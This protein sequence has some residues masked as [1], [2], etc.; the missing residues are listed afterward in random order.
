MS[1]LLFGQ[2]FGHIPERWSAQSL[3][4]SVVVHDHQR[5]NIAHTHESAFVSLMLAGQY[6]E[7]AGRKSFSYVP[8]TAVGHPSEL[9]HH[10]AIGGPG[11]R[12]LF[13]EFRPEL[14]NGVRVDPTALRS[15]RDLSGTR[16]AW[17]LLSLYLDVAAGGE[18]LEFESRAQQV[19]ADIVRVSDR[20]ASDLPSLNR[21]TEYL[22]AHF[23]DHIAMKDVAAAAS[24]HP[25]YL[26]QMFRRHT[27]ETIGSYVRRLRVRAAAECLTSTSKPLAD[28]ALDHGFCDQSHFH[29]VF[30]AWSGFT[31][32]AFRANFR[33]TARAEL[34]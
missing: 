27:G 32:A 11:V 28:V 23:R 20:T 6:A 3:A 5:V 7:T 12:L 15:L 33:A 30:R 24:L 25:V 29:R 1:T 26:G 31:P 10:D 13:F 34:K 18:G 9:E 19:I 21:A 17:E 8:F 22:H 2:A 16:A 14:L 4:L